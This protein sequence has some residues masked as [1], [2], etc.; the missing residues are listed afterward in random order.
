[1]GTRFKSL[2][3]L[4]AIVAATTID[5]GCSTAPPVE[6]ALTSNIEATVEAKLGEEQALDAKVKGLE[7]VLGT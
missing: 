6:V 2:I 7:D 1:M 5:I 3:A 4:L